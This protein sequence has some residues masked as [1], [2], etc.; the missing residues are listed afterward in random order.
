MKK[1]RKP[2]IEPLPLEREVE[3]ADPYPFESLGETIGGAAQAMF[4]GIQAPDGLSPAGSQASEISGKKSNET[5]SV[6]DAKI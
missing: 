5:W 6:N 1:T 2:K 4:D 3:Q